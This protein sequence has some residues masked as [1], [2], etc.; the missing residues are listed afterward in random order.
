MTRRPNNFRIATATCLSFLFAFS[1][2]GS[3][4]DP[5]TKWACFETESAQLPRYWRLIG[6]SRPNVEREIHLYGEHVSGGPGSPEGPQPVEYACRV[7]YMKDGFIKTLWYARK[8]P[9]YCRQKAERLVEKLEAGGLTCLP[10]D[11]SDRFQADE[12]EASKNP[13]LQALPPGE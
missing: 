3:A 11:E 2:L 8:D 5:I 1:N 4:G 6:S 9:S 10:F 13:P 12:S 7:D